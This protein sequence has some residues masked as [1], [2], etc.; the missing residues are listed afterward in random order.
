MPNKHTFRIAPIAKLIDMHIDDSLCVVDPFCGTS[1][2]ANYRNDIRDGGIDGRKY[3][4]S[5]IIKG[6]SADVLLIDPPYSPRQISE[7]YR[8]IGIK[9]KKEDTQNARFM[10]GVKDIGSKL[11]KE[12]GI[13]ICCSWNSNGMGKGRGF[14]LES[15]L[16][17]AHGS[18]HN[19]TIVTVE[20][21]IESKD[22]EGNLLTRDMTIR[23]NRMWWDSVLKFNK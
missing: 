5:L 20:R 21:K 18:A 8:D 4:A 14:F 10:K 3:M 2:I 13:V 22:R 15:V 17:V 19:D 16:L 23:E 1:V 11:V 6:I 7:C 9:V 12:G